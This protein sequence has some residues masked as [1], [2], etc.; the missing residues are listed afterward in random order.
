MA[1]KRL[2]NHKAAGSDDIVAEMIKATTEKGVD[3]IHKICSKIWTTGEWPKE[4]CES[5][6]IPIHKKGDKENC[7]NYRTIVLIPHTSKIILYVIQE[8][9]KPYLLPQSSQEQAGFVLGRRTRDQLL[10]IR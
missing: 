10:N 4:W 8:R 1:I 3:I 2:R 7:N 5:I 9:L 6:Y